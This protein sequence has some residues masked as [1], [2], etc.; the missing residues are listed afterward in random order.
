MLTF[1][2]EMRKGRS[3]STR[4]FCSRY[5]YWTNMI[6]PP[7]IER[8]ALDGTS[9]VEL[10]SSGLGSP[11]ALAVDEENERLYWTDTEL[12]RIECSDLMG[13]NRRVLADGQ[14]I[15]PIGL[16]V[17]GD[18]VYWIDRDQQLIERVNR[19]SGRDRLRVQGRVSHLSDIVAVDTWSSAKHR[20]HPCSRNNGGCSHICVAKADGTTR[21]SCPVDLVLDSGEAQCI[22]PPTCGPDHFTCASGIP[23][24]IPL[25]WMCDGLPECGDKSDEENCP[26]CS[27]GKFHCDNGQCISYREHCDGIPQCSDESDEK[28]CCSVDEF[29]CKNNECIDA[30]HRCNGMKN[31]QDGSDE[32]DCS[33]HSPINAN[34]LPG[35]SQTAQYTVGIVVGF[36]AIVVIVVIA[37]FTCRR[38]NN[39]LPLEESRDIVMVTKPLN[40]N[41]SG[42]STPPH[43]LSTSRGKSATTC[44]SVSTG[45]MG[46]GPPLYDRAHVTG[47]S[48]S[49]STVTHY[50]QE[51]LN[52]PPS[53]ITDRSQCMGDL[54]YSS[55]SPSTV[56]S[57]YRS[58][59]L[60]NIPPTTTPCSTDVCEDSEPYPRPSK[61][62]YNSI[63]ELNYDSD[64]YPPPPT[65]R[66]HYLSDEM[67]SCP[68]S[69]STERS[70]FN[71]YPP[72]PSPVG[73]SDC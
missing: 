25:T 1:S 20:R 37:I 18:Y 49:S 39:H 56:R 55:P 31:C 8:A 63:V 67:G 40:P 65:P 59:R 35:G 71:P 42:G 16:T 29:K 73:T 2:H 10:F 22:E 24:C 12:G 68:P 43:T 34:N 47:A 54:Y 36:I 69:P 15:K 61:K 14:I 33:N 5:M 7:R 11:G 57:Q 21:C 23:D 32:E 50:P 64:P 48:S 44:I 58:Y 26:R 3:N 45:P 9:Q 17:Y 60:R 62:Y 72:P 27:A 51:T 13:G 53:P 66:S 41:Q 28:M 19:K 46:S 70:Y 30:G 4:S 52:P 6:N 38:K